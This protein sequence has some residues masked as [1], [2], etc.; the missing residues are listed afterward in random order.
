MFSFKRLASFC[1]SAKNSSTVGGSLLKH[2]PLIRSSGGII[3]RRTLRC[4]RIQQHSNRLKLVKRLSWVYNHVLGRKHA[5]KFRRT[6][7][8]LSQNIKFRERTPRWLRRNPYETRL[9][10]FANA[11][12]DANWMSDNSQAKSQ[13]CSW[14]RLM[15]HEMVKFFTL[16][17]NKRD[18]RK[19]ERVRVNLTNYFLFTV[20]IYQTKII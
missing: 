1:P 12:S 9:C 7:E 3:K 10:L 4:R 16:F 15:D 5:G 14:S 20:Y 18:K 19:D 11:S 8:T 2:I 17:I 13:T 6:Y